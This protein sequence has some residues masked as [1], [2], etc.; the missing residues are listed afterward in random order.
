MT[1]LVHER[2]T[3]RSGHFH[4]YHLSNTQKMQA[5]HWEYSSDEEQDWSIS[6]DDDEPLPVTGTDVLFLM[7]RKP[8]GPPPLIKVDE[9]PSRNWWAPP[10][11]FHTYNESN[12]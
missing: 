11:Y 3:V 6:D 12:Q 2:T 5:E 7:P 4:S 9:V 8:S 1:R 10:M